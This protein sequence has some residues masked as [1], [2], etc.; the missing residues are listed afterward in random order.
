MA[1][2]RLC[3]LNGTPK[4]Y[5]LD[6]ERIFICT[7]CWAILTVKQ[8]R[9]GLIYI[10][11]YLMK[12]LKLNHHIDDV[13]I[14]HFTANSIGIVLFATASSFERQLSYI[15]IQMKIMESKHF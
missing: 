7:N 9:K 8:L 5:L 14:Y 3:Q 10:D 6:C 1:Q 4:E 12:H 13:V 2:C 15:V 11:V